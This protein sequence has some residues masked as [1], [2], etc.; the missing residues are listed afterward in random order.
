MPTIPERLAK[1]EGTLER[2]DHTLNGNG[3]P[4]LAQKM[5]RFI[6]EQYRLG[7]RVTAIEDVRKTKKLDWQWLVTAVIGI[8]AIAVAFLK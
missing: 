4:G 3:Q 7:D 2:L 5:E 8:G 6:T 1:I